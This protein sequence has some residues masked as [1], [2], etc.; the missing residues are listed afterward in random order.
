[1]APGGPASR[2]RPGHGGGGPAR[3]GH[4]RRRGRAPEPHHGRARPRRDD[5][6]GVGLWLDLVRV[7]PP[8]LG[9]P[10]RRPLRAGGGVGR[11][12]RGAHAAAGAEL[13][14]RR[15]L[16]AFGPARKDVGSFTGSAQRR[17]RPRSPASA[18]T[19]PRRAGRRAGGSPGAPL[20]DPAS[21]RSGPLPAPLGRDA[22]RAHTTHPD[23]AGAPATT[24]VPRQGA[25][26][27]PDVLGRRTGRRHLAA[28][29]R[30][31]RA[32]ALRPD[33]EAVRTS[34]PTRQSAR[35]HPC[36]TLLPCFSAALASRPMAVEQVPSTDPSFLTDP[37][38]D[39]ISNV[40]PN[41]SPTSDAHR[42]RRSRSKPRGSCPGREPPSTTDARAMGSRGPRAR[43]RSTS[44]PARCASTWARRF[45]AST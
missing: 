4:A 37:S 36:V 32:R 15:Y 41:C 5:L 44:R 26:I 29:G 20:P 45:R 35:R 33:R 11:A 42:T 25:A 18:Q 8:A 38:T 27:V 23:P 14:V 34:W 39:L 1:M 19:V 31:S 6:E 43:R 3:A 22:A 2:R 28:R 24:G 16:A 13:L 17:S 12:A 9:A 21:P 40:D 30:Q 10:P 7:P